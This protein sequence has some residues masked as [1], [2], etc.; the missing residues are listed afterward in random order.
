MFEK[1]L[2]EQGWSKVESGV[3]VK[4]CPSPDGQET[5]ILCRSGDRRE[6]EK[7]MHDRFAKRIEEG[8]KKLAGRLERARTCPDRAQVERQIGRLLGRNTRAAGLYDITVKE[9]E[10]DGRSKGLRVKW[11]EKKQ[12]KEWAN[13]S[14]GH[15]LLRTNL[16]GWSAQDLWKTYVQLTQAESAFRTEK[17]ELK[18]RPIWHHKEKRVQ[19]HILFSFLAYAMWKTL[20]QWMARSGLGNGPRT[21][22]EEFARLKAIEVFL[23]TSEAK[24]LRLECVTQPDKAQAVLLQRLRV[25]IPRRIGQLRWE[26]VTSKM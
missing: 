23:P 7:A 12:W 1:H 10:K 17:S 6:K 9:V 19:A 14:E 21:V 8:L 25:Q 20:E 13:L 4:L 18:I 3:E 16:V 5:F 2:L 15:Y 22:L 26:Q 24:E 11:A